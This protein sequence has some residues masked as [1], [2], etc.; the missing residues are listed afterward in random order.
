MQVTIIYPEISRAIVPDEFMAKL[1]VTAW[2]GR[3]AMEQNQGMGTFEKMLFG[4]T[5]SSMEAADS[6]L[7]L[8]GNNL[9]GRKMQSSYLSVCLLVELK[10]SHIKSAALLLYH[11]CH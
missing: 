9:R 2:S 5:E 1:R 4:A 10:S 3:L 8:G 6:R 7:L 11:C